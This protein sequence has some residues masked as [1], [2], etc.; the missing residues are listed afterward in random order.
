[1]QLSVMVTC[2]DCGISYECPKSTYD[3]IKRNG[4]PFR[5]HQCAAKYRKEFLTKL[6]KNRTP[7]Q[8]KEYY[9]K[10]SVKQKE[11]IANMDP[12]AKAKRMAKL[13]NGLAE[14][15]K[16]ISDEEKARISKAHSES[17]TRRWERMSP[18]EQQAVRDNAKKRAT[19]EYRAAQ[20]NRSIAMWA[21]ESPEKRAEH[22]RKIIA[23]GRSKKGDYNG[24][25]VAFTD[26][27]NKSHLANSFYYS[28]N[29][30]VTVK[31]DEFG[32]YN[33]TTK[34]WDFAIFDET[35]KLV[36]L[37]DLDGA[38]YHGDKN[39]YDGLYSKEQYDERR[40]L[41]VPDG[42]KMYIIREEF[43][44]NDFETLLQGV[45]KNYD[46][47][48]KEIFDTARKMPFPYPTYPEKKLLRSFEL[49]RKMICSDKYHRNISLN[50]RTGD[51]LIQH[52]H[53]SIYHAHVGNKPSPYDAWYDDEL[54]MKCIRNR[55]LR[56]LSLDNAR[57]LQG[58]N[59]SKIAPK[60]SVFSAGRAKMIISKYLNDF[61]M[62]FDP[63]S[64][65]SGRMLGTISLGKK[66]VGQDIN[67]ITVRE[68]NEMIK[69]LREYYD[70]DATVVQ[71]DVLTST[72]QYPCLF[73]C[74]PYSDKE[75]WNGTPVDK[76]TCD[77]WIDICLNIF[78]C[79]RYVFVIGKTEKYKDFVAN[80]LITKSHLYTSNEKI[81][82]ID[83]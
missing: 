77:E 71:K 54:L 30:P 33:G 53:H 51:W 82:V 36:A 3:A 73:T 19:P 78:H 11:N 47:Y 35:S 76:R 45:Y 57:I 40:S 29:Y 83:K 32:D 24:L 69:F 46:E 6:N 10:V 74:P 81:I 48:L 49:L 64:G 20:G 23:N 18:E 75:Q 21:N 22:S 39:E 50:T 55:T 52:F 80:E 38:R 68:S 66:Y 44:A 27:F 60:V 43:L 12:D 79:K 7:E 58:F 16:N 41:F 26:L 14:W 34:E 8:K 4:R 56:Q 2:S 31:G 9:A 67:E 1:M 15:K 59:V 70:F 65:F 62:I 13:N 37:V 5:C 72:G 25:D 28:R 42:V 63:F 17:N 61:D